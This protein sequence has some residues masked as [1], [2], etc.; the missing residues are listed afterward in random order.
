MAFQRR[1]FPTYY[2]HDDIPAKK[3]EFEALLK[4]HGDK[5]G[6]LG[7][8]TAK[9]ILDDQTALP[10]PPPKMSVVCSKKCGNSGNLVT[11]ITIL[12]I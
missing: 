3:K 7:D 11:T 9:F 5:L 8:F 1:I 10:F 4:E 12:Y 2:S 6:T